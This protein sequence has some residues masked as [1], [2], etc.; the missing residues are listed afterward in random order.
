MRGTH[1]RHTTITFSKQFLPVFAPK[2]P[3]VSSLP[4]ITK[5]LP[6]TYTSH[7]TTNIPVQYSSVSAVR[8]PPTKTLPPIPKLM[9]ITFENQ[10]T[11]IIPVQ[12]SSASLATQQCISSTSS[13]PKV[14]SCIAMLYGS[15]STNDIPAQYNYAVAQCIESSDNEEDSIHAA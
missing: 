12:C 1:A 11:K 15:Q 8:Q 5:L 4:P 3:S 10:T 7:T 2:L 14:I 13:I 9:P 6:I